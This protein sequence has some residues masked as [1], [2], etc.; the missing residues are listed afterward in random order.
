MYQTVGRRW[1]SLRFA[2][3]CLSAPSDARDAGELAQWDGIAARLRDAES[4]TACSPLAAGLD[5]GRRVRRLR[6]VRA[7]G[8][9]LSLLPSRKTMIKANLG[10]L[11][12]EFEAAAAQ[13]HDGFV[14]AIVV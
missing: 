12:R 11:Q 4:D 13:G 7:A 10:R 5:R 3:L 14:V 8:L 2:S 1:N 6:S 9:R